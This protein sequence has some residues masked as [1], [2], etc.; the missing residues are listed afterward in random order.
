MEFITN[1]WLLI[2]VAFISGAMLLWPYVQRQMSGM[3]DL[4]TLNVTH[5]IN[6]R[7]ALLL[8]VREPKE[9]ENAKLPQA[10]HIPLSQLLSRGSELA[11]HK[12]R[13]II[14]YCARGA[15]SRMAGSILRK[16]GFSEIYN[17]HGGL[18]AWRDSGLPLEKA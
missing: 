7:N 1:N 17:L 16:L 4:G 5:L 9:Y 2:S 11:K 6:T 13:P 10:V 15:R 14:A 12:E 18:Q 3:R 8:D